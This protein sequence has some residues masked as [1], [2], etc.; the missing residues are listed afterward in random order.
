M[1]IEG[2]AAEF[3]LGARRLGPRGQGT[4]YPEALREKA[5]Q[6]LRVRQGAGGPVSV[7]AVE[8]GVG[9]GT[10]L[11]WAKAAAKAPAFLPV[12]VTAAPTDSRVVVYSSNGLRIEGLD[13]AALA[14]LLRQIG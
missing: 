11:R 10:L 14:D 8:L 4:R 7:I 3:R 12:K 9:S 2:L 5:V 13:V 6:Y 1:A